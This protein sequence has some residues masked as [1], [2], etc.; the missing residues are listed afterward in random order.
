[1]CVSEREFLVYCSVAAAGKYQVVIFGR[2]RGG[3]R[4][5]GFGFKVLLIRFCVSESLGFSCGCLLCCGVVDCGCFL[6]FLPAR[7]L[8]GSRG[9]GGICCYFGDCK[10]HYS[11]TQICFGLLYQFPFTKK[12]EGIYDPFVRLLSDEES[13]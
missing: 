2:V 4:G 12:I 8:H 6:L 9:G 3:R 7:W 1:M 5:V 11:E 13:I 10:Y